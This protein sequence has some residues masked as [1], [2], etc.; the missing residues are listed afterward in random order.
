[1]SRKS[2]ERTERKES[3]RWKKDEGGNSREEKS[4]ARWRYLPFHSAERKLS[5][6]ER[7][8]PSGRKESRFPVLRTDG[9]GALEA[10]MLP[11]RYQNKDKKKRRSANSQ[12]FQRP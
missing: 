1:V 3:E 12:A 9:D 8:I 10:G 6:P 4:A 2:T 7:R 5:T 11:D